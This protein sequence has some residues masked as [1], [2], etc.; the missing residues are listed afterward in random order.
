MYIHEMKT[1]K[2]GEN[3]LFVPAV[4]QLNADEVKVIRYALNTLVNTDKDIDIEKT[5]LKELHS[6]FHILGELMLHRHLD[7]WG[8]KR[9]YELRYGTTEKG[10][11][12]E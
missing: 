9:A 2:A 7:D 12:E 1:A 8:L 3:H 10:G 6:N 5:L 4:I 11:V